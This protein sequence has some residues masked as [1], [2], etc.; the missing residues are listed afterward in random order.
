MIS[1]EEVKKLADLA[2]LNVPE[3]ELDKLA[4]DL[5]SILGYVSELKNA[6]ISPAGEFAEEQKLINV[7]REDTNPHES[8]LYTADLVKAFSKTRDNYLSVKPILAKNE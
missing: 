7:L 1:I 6:P 8:G 5:E 3:G 2:R 4:K